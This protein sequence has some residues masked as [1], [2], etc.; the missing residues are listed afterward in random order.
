MKL[1][2]TDW[3]NRLGGMEVGR[4]YFQGELI[5]TGRDKRLV[6]ELARKEIEIGNY[7]TANININNDFTDSH[8]YN[9]IRDKLWRKEHPEYGIINLSLKQQ[10]P[11]ERFKEY[12]IFCKERNIEPPKKEFFFN[13]ENERH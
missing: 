7:I 13:H 3:N 11:L 6:E 8:K 5:V 1:W 2:L 10:T 4:D 9:Y 12:T